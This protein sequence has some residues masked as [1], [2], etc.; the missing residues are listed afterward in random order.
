[1]RLK[2]KVAIITG[3]GTGIG[4]AI[5]KAFASEGAKVVVTGRRKRELER[6]VRDIERA[7]GRALAAP[8]SVTQ[9]A[10]VRAA[11]DATVRAYGRVDVLVNNAGNLFYAG[12]GRDPSAG[13]HGPVGG[14]R[15]ARGLFCL[16]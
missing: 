2:D 14:D 10:D 16:G 1:M 15:A 5:A 3:G 9:E 8:G 7:K 13:P 4:E 12:A 11:V 6:V